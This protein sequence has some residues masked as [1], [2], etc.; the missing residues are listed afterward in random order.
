MIIDWSNQNQH[1][2]KHLP[3]NDD[4]KEANK[5]SFSKDFH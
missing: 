1:P 5:L 4:F 3:D 2:G